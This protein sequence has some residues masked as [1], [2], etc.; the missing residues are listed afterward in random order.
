MPHAFFRSSGDTGP[1]LGW[2]PN[3]HAHL[4]VRKEVY[5]LLM[6]TTTITE[7]NTGASIGVIRTSPPPIKKGDMMLAI[8]K[9]AEIVKESNEILERHKNV[10]SSTVS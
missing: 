5:T 3:P 1:D 10:R 6:N 2:G 4:N 7:S 9:M 8:K